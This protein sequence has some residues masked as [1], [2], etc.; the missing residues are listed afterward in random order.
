MVW[1]VS[2]TVDLWS[3]FVAVEDKLTPVLKQLVDF[4]IKATVCGSVHG[5]I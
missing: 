2:K 4:H 1:L 5:K 3:D